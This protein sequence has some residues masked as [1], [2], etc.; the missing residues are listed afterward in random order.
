[1][2]VSVRLSRLLAAAVLLSAAHGAVWEADASRGGGGPRA[3]V[4]LFARWRL[5]RGGV[6]HRI[7]GRHQKIFSPK[8]IVVSRADP[9]PVL[10][11]LEWTM[12]RAAQGARRQEGIFCLQETRRVLHVY[13]WK[14]GV[15]VSHHRY[16]SPSLI[17][18]ALRR[19][20]RK[21]KILW[22]RRGRSFIR[23]LYRNGRAISRTTRR[24]ERM[25]V[26]ALAYEKERKY[27]RDEPSRIEVECGGGVTVI[28]S[29]SRN[30]VE[31]LGER[32]AGGKERR[33]PPRL[34]AGS[35]RRRV[36][37]AECE[38]AML[39]CAPSRMKVLDELLS[40]SP[41][42]GVE[43]LRRFL[44]LGRLLV[45]NARSDDLP[46]VIRTIDGLC[47][48]PLP[49]GKT[50]DELLL[51]KALSE[52]WTGVS[53]A[54]P[55]WLEGRSRFLAEAEHLARRGELPTPDLADRL[56]ESCTPLEELPPLIGR[57]MRRHSA[58]RRFLPEDFPIDSPYSLGLAL[59]YLALLR[60]G[61]EYGAES[62][63]RALETIHPRSIGEWLGWWK[64]NGYHRPPAASPSSRT[65]RGRGRRAAVSNRPRSAILRA[66]RSTLRPLVEQRP[67]EAACWPV[68][69]PVEAPATDGVAI[70]VEMDLRSP[71]L[72]HVRMT[73]ASRGECRAYG[74]VP[75][76]TA[77]SRG[78]PPV[79]VPLT[80]LRATKTLRKG[81][82]VSTTLECEAALPPL[83]GPSN[84]G[85]EVT[86]E[87]DGTVVVFVVE[88]TMDGRLH[89]EEE[90]DESP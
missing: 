43:A 35:S 32:G 45:E 51:L 52:C 64:R 68:R 69:F 65:A 47:E 39:D 5:S 16:P 54:A 31:V 38:K 22:V 85:L 46:A 84:I 36:F 29:A 41:P 30:S 23:I 55:D 26:W 4:T 20:L 42:A 82:R 74:L 67:V 37:L 75:R 73:V 25:P 18:R 13:G 48:T 72:L 78:E 21:E 10:A 56:S 86:L 77:A 15:V 80:L 24:L 49:A 11:W 12:G 50:R 63:L 44:R 60:A 33:T 7:R 14:R 79:Q 53:T 57:L 40:S 87:P 2:V 58:L 81:G 61:D 34:A 6:L 62:A 90:P 17:P 27:L 28:L 66:Y 59:R 8:R 9:S 88:C 83:E 70:G 1:M 19:R 71:R 3:A 76:L 89:R